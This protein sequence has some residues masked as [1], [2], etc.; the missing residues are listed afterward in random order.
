MFIT[1]YLLVQTLFDLVIGRNKETN[2]RY[3]FPE[4]FTEVYRWIGIEKKGLRQIITNDKSALSPANLTNNL[5][6]KINVYN[7]KK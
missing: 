2:S 5:V 7:C 1:K 4:T 3:H 6:D